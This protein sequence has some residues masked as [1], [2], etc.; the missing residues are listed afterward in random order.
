MRILF[1]FIIINFVVLSAQT[2]DQVK[3][4]LESKGINLEQAKQIARDKGISD[5]QIEIEAKKR[6]VELKDLNQN[7]K[8]VSS[9]SNI[10]LESFENTLEKNDKSVINNLDGK[11]HNKDA[12]QLQYFGY[13][14]FKGDPSAFQSSG[15]GAVDPNYNIGAGDQIIIMLWGESEFRQ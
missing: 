12:L 1:Y 4:Q 11:Y 5:S 7:D 13:Q 9:N 15:F 3:R 10:D 2:V 6:G 14:I 8:S